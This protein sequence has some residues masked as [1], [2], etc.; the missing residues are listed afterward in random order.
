MIVPETW[1]AK[2]SEAISARHWEKTNMTQELHI[3]ST[4]YIC[5]E[6][7]DTFLN[8][9][10]LV[11]KHSYTIPEILLIQFEQKIYPGGPECLVLGI[12]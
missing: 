6:N 5:R 4:L 7:Q 12:Y 2:D 8:M 1:D 9:R 11:I 3:A 10:D